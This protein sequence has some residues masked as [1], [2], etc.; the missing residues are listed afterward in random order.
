MRSSRNRRTANEA[1]RYKKLKVVS[2]PHNTP[3]GPSSLVDHVED[4]LAHS[5]TQQLLSYFDKVVCD[6]LVI[7][8]QD[9]P[10]PFRAYVLP[11][12]YEHGGILHAV[13][14]LA[15]CHM[16]GLDDKGEDMTLALVLILL[17]VDICESGISTHG[18]HLTGTSIICGK[19]CERPNA[20]ES[21]R[22]SFLL[23]ILAWLDVLR[24]FSGAEKLSY[25][26]TVRE[27]VF[28][29]EYF[30]LETLVGCPVDFFYSI[31]TVLETAKN[32]MNGIVSL[33]DF[34]TVLSNAKRFFQS[35]NADDSVYPSNDPMWKVLAEAYRHVCII[36]ILRFPDTCAIPCSAV[37]IQTSVAAILDVAAEIPTDSPWFKRLVFPP[38]MA[39]TETA[40]PHQ[41]G[42]VDLCM[43]EI[44]RTTGF[45]HL[46]IRDILTKVW[47]A[48]R[49][50]LNMAVNVP[51][52]EF[53]CSKDLVRQHD[54]LFL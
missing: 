31:G 15:E 4:I 38:F 21:P 36:R 12:A 54:Y 39:G 46:A 35:W 23:A 47:D 2:S 8:N 13:L 30:N 24:G 33:D 49:G 22:K 37:E 3:G 7:E 43:N 26:Q 10:N 16:I 25:H 50:Q 14:C 27:Q 40:V 17:L 42:Y 18:V 34:Q 48:R 1:D 45:Q 29:A 53:T 41:R 44:K 11:F 28:R 6:S 20:A 51:W 32:H 52:M 5:E 9:I 19:I